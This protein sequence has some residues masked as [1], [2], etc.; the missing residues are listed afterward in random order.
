M[1]KKIYTNLLLTLSV[2]EVKSFLFLRSSACG[3][4]GGTM[5]YSLADCCAPAGAAGAV[6]RPN[7]TGLMPCVPVRVCQ[8]QMQ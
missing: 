7:G 8:D 1:K 4:V 5:F 3:S 2:L 6:E